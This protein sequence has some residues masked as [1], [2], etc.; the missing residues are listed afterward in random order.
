MRHSRKAQLSVCSKGFLNKNWS[1]SKQNHARGWQDLHRSSLGCHCRSLPVFHL[2]WGPA[3]YCSRRICSTCC[4]P[5]PPPEETRTVSA[6]N[7]FNTQNTEE[8]IWSRCCL[9]NVPKKYIYKKSTK[10]RT[11]LVIMWLGVLCPANQYSYIKA[12]DSLS[13]Q[14]F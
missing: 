1:Q 14:W 9:E 3:D 5:E 11:V 10:T 8:Q 7:G 12:K 13:C 6:V 2:W 4:C